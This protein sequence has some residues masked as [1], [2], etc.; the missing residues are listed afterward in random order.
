MP[1]RNWKMRVSDILDC[2]ARIS[3]YTQGYTLEDF[4]EDQKTIDAVV[5]NLEIIGEAA[6]HIP[7]EIQARYADLPCM[8]MR[9]IRNI[10]LHEYHGVN[11][12]IIW[13]TVRENLPP[14]ILRLKEILEG[15]PS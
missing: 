14:I 3:Q 13:H 5:R 7:S 9:T 2:I 15:E 6:N 11:L 1:P 8:E 12:E 10:V 4:R